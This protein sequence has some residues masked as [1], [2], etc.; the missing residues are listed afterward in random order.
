MSSAKATDGPVI[1]VIDDDAG[2]ANALR[3]VLELNGARC[4]L[5]TSCRDALEIIADA[6]FLSL[7]IHGVLAD[8]RLPDG[9]GYKVIDVFRQRCPD[10]PVAVM[11]AYADDD[12]QLWLR[13]RDV[14]FLQ[15][16]LP[17][18]RLLE[19]LEAA[20]AYAGRHPT[21]AAEEEGSWRLQLNAG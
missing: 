5:G 12:L 4:V 18:K 1:L 7:S 15:K 6:E 17:M 21:P 20:K 19:W 14:P 3:Q 8:V 16:P 11:T 2:I 13:E 10:V 9:L